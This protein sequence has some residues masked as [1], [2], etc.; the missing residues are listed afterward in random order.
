MSSKHVLVFF[1]LFIIVYP[2]FG[3]TIEGKAFHWSTFQPLPN[4]IVRVYRND[5]LTDQV[6]C[7]QNGYYRLNLPPG[8]YVFKAFTINQTGDVCYVTQMNITLLKEKEIT[9]LDLPMFP[10]LGDMFPEIEGLPYEMIEDLPE[11]EDY[12]VISLEEGR[13]FD[14]MYVIFFL[15]I[16]IFIPTFLYLRKTKYAEIEGLAEDET[17][18][19]NILKRHGGQMFQTDLTKEIGYSPAKVSLLLSALEE[20]EVI[21]KRVKGRMNIIL[22]RSKK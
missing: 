20:K 5:T 13:K 21:E 11:I 8:S 7:D 16:I 1:M 6:T 12:P 9:R 17:E 3:T 18:V 4:T 19:I 2:C 15:L 10:E 22:L 14:L